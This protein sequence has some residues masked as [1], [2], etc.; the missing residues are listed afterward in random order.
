VIV[1]TFEEVEGEFVEGIAVAVGH[2]L[3]EIDGSCVFI[4]E[5]DVEDGDMEGV[6]LGVEDG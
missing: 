3:G 6:Q 1:G 2:S 5:G 4:C